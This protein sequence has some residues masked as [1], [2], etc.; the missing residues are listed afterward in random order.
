M[1]KLRG[2]KES[3]LLPGRGWGW[4]MEGGGVRTAREAQMWFVQAESCS[5]TSSP[6]PLQALETG[7]LGCALRETSSHPTVRR[8]GQ[9]SGTEPGQVR[10]DRAGRRRLA[11]AVLPSS[12]CPRGLSL[13]RGYIW[14]LPSCGCSLQPT[15]LF[16]DQPPGEGPD[17]AGHKA[18]M[19]PWT[20][21]S[22]GE[23]S[24]TAMVQGM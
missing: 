21:C 3:W 14:G 22:L 23:W 8:K 17:S 6:L 5:Y 2:W 15:G 12:L 18:W 13:A 24:V 9:T 7:T 4:G 1:H 10:A 16:G 11:R 19:P 20:P